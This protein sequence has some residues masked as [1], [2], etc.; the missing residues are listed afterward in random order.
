M[1][2][3][4]KLAMGAMA[5]TM[6]I[7]MIGGGTWAAFNDIEE[8]NATVAAGELHFDLKSLNNGPINFNVSNLKPGDTM[9]RSIKLQNTGTLAI[10]DVMLSIDN[11]DFT[12][13]NPGDIVDADI[14]GV[15]DEIEYLSQ[16]KVT[17]AKVGAETGSGPDGGF[18]KDIIVDDI[19]L[20]DLYLASALSG[21]DPAAQA[22]AR[23]TIAANV[24]PDYYEEG[25]INVSTVNPDEWSGLPLIPRD[26]DNLELTIEFDEYSQRDDR[27]VEDQNRFQG[28][29]ADVTFTF[30]A[31]Q[32]GGQEVTDED[33]DGTDVR[34]NRMAN[35]GEPL[36]D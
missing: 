16:F 28:D 6:G 18:P 27:G 32:W 2:I 36:L 10:K 33:M 24:N 25:R 35:N 12:D 1:N 9:T 30:E 8:A 21:V 13:Y 11:V 23:S 17:V 31:R 34:T 4:K 5:A 15:N 26:P 7:S 29:T 19:T 22:T 3:K 20:A 14:W